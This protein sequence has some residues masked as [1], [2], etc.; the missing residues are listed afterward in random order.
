[1]ATDPA[2]KQAENRSKPG[3]S[4]IKKLVVLGCGG[5]IGSHLLEALLARPNIEI[6]GADPSVSKIRHLIGHPNL[7]LHRG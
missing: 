3:L 7:R 5:Y 1:M 6:F 2:A 4:K